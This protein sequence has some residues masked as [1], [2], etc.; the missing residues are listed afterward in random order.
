[1]FFQA[2]EGP[3]V[4]AHRALGQEPTEAAELGYG[5]AQVTREG[6]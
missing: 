2:K 4:P 6:L 1:M 3:V 5:R